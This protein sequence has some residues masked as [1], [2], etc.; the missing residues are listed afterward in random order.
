MRSVRRSSLSCV[1]VVAVACGASSTY[2]EPPPNVAAHRT[3]IFALEADGGLALRVY[4]LADGFAFQSEL[5]AERVV[6]TALMYTA[7]PE[8]LGLPL[9]ELDAAPPETCGAAPLPVADRVYRFDAT[10]DRTSGWQEGAPGEALAEFRWK[11][12][13][14]CPDFHLVREFEIENHE[15]FAVAAVD[16]TR[17]LLFARRNGASTGYWLTTDGATEVAFDFVPRADA[18]HVAGDD[19][20]ISEDHTLYRGDASG[21]FVRT[22]STSTG[23]IVSIDGPA[24]DLFFIS[25]QGV[26]MHMGEGQP[27]VWATRTREGST[28]QVANVLRLGPGHVAVSPPGLL[29]FEVY[30]DGVLIDQD[31]VLADARGLFAMTTL[32]DFGVFALYETSEVFRYDDASLLSLPSP[33]LAFPR[34]LIRYAPDVAVYGT[35]SGELQAF[36]RD[37]GF[38]DTRFPAATAPSIQGLVQ[39]GSALLVIGPPPG[40]R[41]I[42][43]VQ[44]LEAGLS[45][46]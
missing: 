32:E 39:L 15:V 9:G 41:A 42:L 40:S 8:A 43:R 20:W 11:G 45:E 44:V 5:E 14:P 3:L 29:D 31:S 16:D 23:S 34:A 10:R 7:S 1:F 33:R 24:D 19:I 17:A 25:D 6:G 2:L 28:S 22:A 46:G 13:C 30:R 37:Y 36:V 12:A 21:G 18:V 27:Q 38:C 35:V 4:D 26:L